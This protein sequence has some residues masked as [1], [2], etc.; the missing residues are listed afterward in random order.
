MEEEEQ[1]IAKRK[2]CMTGK[3]VIERLES[4]ENDV[5]RA[6]GEI[7]EELC[8]F[9][10]GDEVALNIEDRV[11]RLER[12]TK[13]LENKVYKL[14]K[15][16]KQRKYRH[17][18]EGLEEPMISCSQYSIFDSQEVSEAVQEIEDEVMVM[19]DSGRPEKYDKKPLDSDLSGKTRRRRAAAKREI[20]SE[21][22]EEE[23]VTVSKLLG[24]LLYVENWM[25]DKN[26]AAMGWKLFHGEVAEGKPK[27]SVEEAI[28]L[29]EKSGM[30]EHVLQEVRLRLLDR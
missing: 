26:V 18:P 17:N 8:P 5:K 19:G 28:W 1:P 2:K 6:V 13:L 29:R 4:N 16:V 21:W 14:K 24:Y 12:V 30:S 11:E 9:D 22:A 15:A 27:L 25:V 20:L 3:E 7:V 10:V 23:K